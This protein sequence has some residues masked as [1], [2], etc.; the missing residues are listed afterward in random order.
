MVEKALTIDDLGRVD[1]DKL[2]KVFLPWT[3][4]CRDCRRQ[5]HPSV[6]LVLANLGNISEMQITDLPAMTL[7]DIAWADY[8]YECSSGESYPGEF[9]P[10]LGD[11]FV[12]AGLREAAQDRQ[13]PA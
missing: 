7:R 10:V 3:L 9:D 4:E 6:G 11:P 13:E 8:C 2:Y 12:T 1:Y 5:F